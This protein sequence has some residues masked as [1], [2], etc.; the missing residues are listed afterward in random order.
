MR[1]VRLA[2]RLNAVVTGPSGAPVLVFLHG[3]GCGQGMWRHV[4]PAFAA[5]HRIVL[6]DLPGS[7][8][9]DPAAYDAERHA[10]LDGYADDVL[11]VL[12]E[13]GLGPDTDGHT[14]GNPDG[15]TIVGHSVAS[16]IGV[17]AHVA[18]PSVVTRL[19]LVSP[20]ARYIDDGDYRGGFTP[21]D[22]DDLLETM[23]RNHLGWQRPLSGLVAG[24]DQP[25]TQA[26]L[27]DSFCRTPPDIAAQFAAVTFHGDNRAD[28]DLVTAPTL[29]LQVREDAIAPM[30]VGQYVHDHIAGSRFVV[31]ETR[32]HA[33]HVSD[34]QDVIEAI[35]GFLGA[36]ASR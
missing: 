25:M 29:V 28:L 14:H 34:P 9:A 35:G 36:P 32:G 5:D 21:E 33:P 11:Q 1:P 2:S 24:A 12:E 15:V 3:F 19:V 31:L 16:M 17:L 10:S 20:S 26:E 4:T 23:D 27:E 6:L 13:L 18:A 22:V 30:S 7:G 8:D